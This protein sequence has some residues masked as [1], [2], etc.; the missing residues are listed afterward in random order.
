MGML[1][2]D[3]VEAVAVAQESD[4]PWQQHDGGG[5]PNHPS[6]YVEVALRDGALSIDISAGLRW[7]WDADDADNDIVHWRPSIPP[8]CRLRAGEL[9][10]EHAPVIIAA[11]RAR[12]L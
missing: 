8:P 6:A 3:R 2:S 7:V 10:I 12:G 5:R 4:E 11:L 1:L 9:L